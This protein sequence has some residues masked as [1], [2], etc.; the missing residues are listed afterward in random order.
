MHCKLFCLYRH[1]FRMETNLLRQYLS[2]QQWRYVCSIF[3]WP[4]SKAYKTEVCGKDVFTLMLK[5][6]KHRRVKTPLFLHNNLVRATVKPKLAYCQ[7]DDYNFPRS[8][9]AFQQNNICNF[10]VAYWKIYCIDFD[11]LETTL[12][13]LLKILI[14]VLDTR[15]PVVL[16]CLKCPR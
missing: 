12:F 10:F 4:P 13:C 3:Q 5:Q 8:L 11:G 2:G 6:G 1:N 7:T 15:M 14:G 9:E 16:H